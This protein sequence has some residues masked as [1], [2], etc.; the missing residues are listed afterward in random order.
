MIYARGVNWHQIKDQRSRE[1]HQVIAN[2]LRA[3]PDT[4][5]LAERRIEAR[6]SD[7]RYSEQSKDAMGEWLELIRQ[8]G[9]PGVLRVLE[10]ASEEPARMRQSSPFA[11]LMPEQER[12]S[13]LEKYEPLRTRASLAG[14]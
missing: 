3:S 11:F 2:I 8:E 9:L 13:I 7:P 4:L 6:L 10:D 1:M 5:R 12:L 14:V